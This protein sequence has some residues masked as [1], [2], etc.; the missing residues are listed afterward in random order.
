MP[1][2][3]EAMRYPGFSHGGDVEWSAVIFVVPQ[4]LDIPDGYIGRNRLSA[5]GKIKGP[6]THWN[7]FSPKI[8]V[9]ET[10]HG[11]CRVICLVFYYIRQYSV[12]DKE[13]HNLL[14]RDIALGS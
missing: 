12:V 5:K 3:T 4:S 14:G 7:W 10:G 8:P 6:D 13:S 11:C 9:C 2:G 1:I